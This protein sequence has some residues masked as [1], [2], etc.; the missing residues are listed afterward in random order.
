MQVSFFAYFL[1]K[2]SK[3]FS[4]KV[5][6]AADKPHHIKGDYQFAQNKEAPSKRE[7]KNQSSHELSPTR[8]RRD[9][10]APS[11]LSALQTSPHTVGSHPPGG[12]L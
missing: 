11:P 4:K 5:S 6:Q 12:G 9:A 3:F 2:E 7:F 1:F 8:L 10:D